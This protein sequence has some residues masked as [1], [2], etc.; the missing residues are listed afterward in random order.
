M[1]YL[2]QRF[3]SISFIFI[4]GGPP[5]F[6]TI[7]S[8]VL[9][10]FVNFLTDSKFDVSTSLLEQEIIFLQFFL[11]CLVIDF[12]IPLLPPRIIALLYFFIFNFIASV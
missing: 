7:I 8:A 12:P 9:C 10:I 2:Y 6:K 1:K 3:S 11:K 5:V 4:G